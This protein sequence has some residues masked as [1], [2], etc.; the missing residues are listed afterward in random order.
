M[1]CKLPKLT[2]GPLNREVSVATSDLGNGSSAISAAHG[3][4][5]IQ[6]IAR[7]F[8]RQIVETYPAGGGLNQESRSTSE[9]P[10]QSSF[11][12]DRLLQ[13]YMEPLMTGRRAACRQLVQD[14]VASGFEPRALYQ[15]LI[16]PAM[17]YVDEA[18]RDDR[19]STVTQNMAT[20]INRIVADQLQQ[21]LPSQASNGRRILITCA[22]GEQEEIGGQ[23][24]A[25]LFEADGWEVT[26]V[27]GGVPHD[28][29]VTL[30]GQL[31]PEMMLIFGSKPQDTPDVRALIDRI[32]EI[33]ACPTMNIMVSGGVF[34][35]ADGLWK[36]VKADLLA[37]TAVEALDIAGRAQART[38]EDRVPGAPKKRRRRRKPPLLATPEDEN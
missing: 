8:D 35:R 4:R 24:C 11:S 9:N 3:L 19:I 16:W 6:R 13:Q 1:A 25:D 31:R 26:F 23:M 34:T 33:D 20:C 7:G 21:H 10:M 29:V 5:G 22:R 30:I 37:E 14:A 15:Q 36:E 27:G 2:D 12:S 18:Y 38:P 32:R 28:E 17:A